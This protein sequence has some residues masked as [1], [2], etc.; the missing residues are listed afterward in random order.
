M[1]PFTTYATDPLYKAASAVIEESNSTKFEVGDTVEWHNGPITFKEKVIKLKDGRLA[2][3]GASGPIP[4]TSIRSPLT[5]VKEDLDEGVDEIKAKVEKLKV[6]DKTN[7][8]TVKK[9][10][11]TSISFHG[12]D[13]GTNK[14]QFNQRKMGSKDFVLDKLMKLKED[15]DLEEQISTDAID[16]AKKHGASHSSITAF[17]AAKQKEGYSDRE[18]NNMLW[19]GKLKEVVEEL[20]DDILDEASIPSVLYIHGKKIGYNK[21]IV[22]TIYKATVEK[23]HY[24]TDKEIYRAMALAFTEIEKLLK[25]DAPESVS[26]ITEAVMPRDATVKKAYESVINLD[27]PQLESFLYMFALYMRATG[28]DY[29]DDA[30]VNASLHIRKAA[31]AD[32]IYSVW[33]NVVPERVILSKINSLA[34]SLD[35]AKRT[36]VKIKK[37]AI[38]QKV[39]PINF[40]N[41]FR[42]ADTKQK[43]NTEYLGNYEV[44]DTLKDDPEFLVFATAKNEYWSVHKSNTTVVTTFKEDTTEITEAVDFSKLPLSHNYEIA[45]R[46]FDLLDAFDPKLTF[47]KS[48]KEAT[49]GKLTTDSYYKEVKDL[50]NRY[51]KFIKKVANEAKLNGTTI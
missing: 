26:E 10:D 36:I 3:P 15:V 19:S 28:L 7:F 41:G 1:K 31:D 42:L 4:L 12:K 25:E 49:N 51:S 21:E 27:A 34:E 35:E 6:G 44:S 37:G 43:T 23:G 16:T 8:G 14:I 9:I 24:K 30:Q 38:I 22:D 29:E 50:L 11:G 33:K 17:I 47:G 39:K 18:I 45:G 20:D 46:M 13:I 48:V 32:R 5:K 2:V 40:G